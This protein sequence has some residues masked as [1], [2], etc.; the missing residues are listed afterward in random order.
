MTDAEPQVAAR[1]RVAQAITATMAAWSHGASLAEIRAGFDV[2]LAG[3]EPA[4]V[5]TVNIAGMEGVLSVPAGAATGAVVLFC[6]GGGFQ[7]GS[8]RSHASLMSRLAETSGVRVLGFEYRLAP[9]HRFPAASEDCFSAYRALLTG[10]H[11]ACQIIVAGDSA[12]GSL[13]LGVALQARDQGL[14]LPAGIVLI[15]PWLDLNLRGASYVTRAGRDI[16]SK[17]DQLRAMARTYLGRGG[18][19][20]HPLAAPLDAPLD[21]LP[22]LLIHAGD[23]DITLDDSVLLASRARA[24]GVPCTLRVWAEMYHH[25]QVFAELSEAQQSLDEIGGF[26]RARLASAGE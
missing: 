11:G 25:F 5:D 26:I 18:D 15:S 7:I 14:P 24:A 3:P 22:P 9:E 17:P 1:A 13:A 2:L 10:G 16:F 20:G 23:Y 19:H 8:V 21:G 4:R 6:H 12:G